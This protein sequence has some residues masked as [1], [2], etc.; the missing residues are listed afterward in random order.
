MLT[1]TAGHAQG[2]NLSAESLSH[3]DQLMVIKESESFLLGHWAKIPGFF[4]FKLSR[5]HETHL[6]AKSSHP[7]PGQCSNKRAL[8]LKLSKRIMI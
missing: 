3:G 7:Q 8:L 5:T 4:A 2:Y 6:S 1:S